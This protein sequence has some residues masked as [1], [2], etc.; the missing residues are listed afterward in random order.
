M[1]ARPCAA[2]EATR[3][4]RSSG[5][6]SR[7]RPPRGAQSLAYLAKTVAYTRRCRQLSRTVSDSGSTRPVD[8]L[9]QPID[10]AER[11]VSQPL[12]DQ[13]R[14]IA[15]SALHLLL[16]QRI[17]EPEIDS[18]PLHAERISYRSRRLARGPER[19][20]LVVA[21]AELVHGL[22]HA[23]DC[24]RMTPRRARGRYSS[25]PPSRSRGGCRRTCGGES[26][27]SP[28]RPSDRRVRLRGHGRGLKDHRLLAEYRGRDSGF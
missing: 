1:P 19:D 26:S 2:S 21:G 10:C 25:Y 17:A 13:G 3:C 23:R 5:A 15:D 22:R 7:S 6:L 24:I 12:G 11:V 4:W 20:G 18:P 16:D 14:D 27:G 28:E 8:D 9:P